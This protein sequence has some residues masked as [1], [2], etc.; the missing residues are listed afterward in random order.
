MPNNRPNEPRNKER[1]VNYENNTLE[2][3]FS[4]LEAL[5]DKGT[6]KENEVID[7]SN[8]NNNNNQGRRKVI[9]LDHEE[10]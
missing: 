10:S 4:A 1:Y 7:L 2:D 9:R 5:I 3:N 6:G 8:E